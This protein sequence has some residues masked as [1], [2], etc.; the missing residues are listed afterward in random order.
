MII[1]PALWFAVSLL[2]AW[3][4]E[5]TVEKSGSPA[6][7]VGETSFNAGTVAP[8][9]TVEHDFI[10]RNSGDA[11]LIIVKVAPGCGCSVAEHDKVIAPGRS[12]KITIKITY[13]PEWAG[14]RISRSA[15]VET[16]D[17]EAQV[18]TLTVVADVAAK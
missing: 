13:A 9:G 15:F 11:D 17:P 12:G 6:L 4:L 3:P 8:G 5:A 14:R 1:V 7:V 16:N 18:A 10:V 2:A